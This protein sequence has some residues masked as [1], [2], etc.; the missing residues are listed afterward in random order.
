ML[1]MFFIGLDKVPHVKHALGHFLDAHPAIFSLLGLGSISSGIVLFVVMF[2]LYKKIFYQVKMEPSSV[3]IDPVLI[4][5][6][7]ESCLKQIVPDTSIRCEVIIT[8]DQLI[9]I[10]TK[11]PSLSLQEHEKILNTAKVK[12]AALFKEKLGYNKEFFFTVSIDK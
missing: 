7:V 10:M 4:Q 6:Y 11:L 8:K 3:I 5:G 9:E 1:G 2:H 12:I